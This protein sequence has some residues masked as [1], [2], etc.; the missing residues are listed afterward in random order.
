MRW[1]LVLFPCL[2]QI[3]MVFEEMLAESLM[4]LA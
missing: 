2:L 4:K 1:G 3:L